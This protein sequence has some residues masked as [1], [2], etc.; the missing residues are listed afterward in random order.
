[1][2]RATNQPGLKINAAL[3]SFP[4]RFHSA[5]CGMAG[6][7]AISNAVDSPSI[8]AAHMMRRSASDTRPASNEYTPAHHETLFSLQGIALM[9]PVFILF[10]FLPLFW[11]FFDASS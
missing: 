4:I 8:A 7:N 11:A 6:P 1:M 9:I 5:G 10:S 3:I 2:N